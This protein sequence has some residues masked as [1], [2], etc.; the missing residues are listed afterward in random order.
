MLF[1]SSAAAA[2]LSKRFALRPSLVMPMAIV[3]GV[4]VLF[5]IDSLVLGIVAVGAAAAMTIRSQIVDWI[6][7]QTSLR[8]AKRL[9]ETGDERW[10]RRYPEGRLALRIAVPAIVLLFGLV[11]IVQST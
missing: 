10:L 11:T 3:I 8:V 6:R 9:A 4:V 1:E 7:D 2:S 5:I